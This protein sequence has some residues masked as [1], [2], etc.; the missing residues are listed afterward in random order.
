MER[1][2]ARRGGIGVRGNR[3]TKPMANRLKEASITDHDEARIRRAVRYFVRRA[4]TDGYS[5]AQYAFDLLPFLRSDV[6]AIVEDETTNTLADLI[7][8]D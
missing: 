4:R 5:E 2:G 8:S 1:R 7:T 6:R 3:V